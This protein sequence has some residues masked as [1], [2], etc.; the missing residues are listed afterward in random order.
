MSNSEVHT[1]SQTE[2]FIWTTELDWSSSVN[3]VQLLSYSK[4]SLLV[5]PVVGIEPATSRW[6]HSNAFQPNALC[7][8]PCVPAG[9]ISWNVGIIT[10]KMRSIVL[11]ILS[12][13]NYQASLQKFKQMN[14]FCLLVMKKST[15]QNIWT[16]CKSTQ[17][18][19]KKQKKTAIFFLLF[20]VWGVAMAFV[21][22]MWN[23]VNVV[24]ELEF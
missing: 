17:L 10:I 20:L 7:T 21:V 23:C 22:N 9:Y 12:N 2:P 14:Y 24:N 13:N 3:H 19:K 5:L 18:Y 1:E 6:F 4:Y 15:E 16:P 11:N 8:V